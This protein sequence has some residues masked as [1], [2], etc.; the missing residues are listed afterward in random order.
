L[1]KADEV[2][3]E[4]EEMAESEFWPIIRLDKGKVL[5]EVVRKVKPKKVL[6]VG[7]LIGCS[8]IL[9]G[10]ELDKKAMI[11]TIEIH[12]SE[13][14]TAEENIKRSGIPPKV[15]VVVGDALKVLPRLKGRFD[16]VFI[17]ADKTEYLQYL[18]LMEDKLHEG[19]VVVADNAVS[20]L[21]RRGTIWI[22]LGILRSTKAASSKLAKTELKL[23][24]KCKTSLLRLIY[25]QLIKEKLFKLPNFDE[26]L[27]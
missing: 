1:T 7:T 5:A 3:R 8:A 14:K 12:A 2:L 25:A 6:E 13:A 22:T 24:S 16:A 11:T 17:D 21:T 18:K 26:R 10:K 15:N 20:S 23:A 19:T 9:I 27:S 4:I